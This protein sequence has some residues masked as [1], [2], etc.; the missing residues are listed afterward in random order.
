M[1]SSYKYHSLTPELIG[2]VKPCPFCGE[3]ECD[4]VEYEKTMWVKCESCKATGP[5]AKGKQAYAEAL[6]KWNKRKEQ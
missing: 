1:A 5:I 2:C 4:I 3:Y 6:L